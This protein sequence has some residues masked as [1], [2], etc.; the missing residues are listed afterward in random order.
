MPDQLQVPLG[1]L[2][3]LGVGGPA[4]RV[5]TAGSAAELVAAV[6]D[7]DAA[8]EPVL[9]LAGGSNVVVADA[10]FPG[11]VVLVR[12]RGI[13]TMRDGTGATRLTAQAGE[14]WDDLVARCVDR[15]LSGLECLSGIPGSTGATPIQNVGAYGQEVADTVVAVRAWDRVERCTVEL[16]RADCRFDY[17]DSMLKHTDRYVVLD[18]TFE[19]TPERQCRAL[20]YAEL[21]AAVGEEIGGRVPL[22]QARDAV[23]RLRRGKGMVIDPADP[24]SRS[25]G[26]F[27]T[28]PVLTTADYETLVHRAGASPPHWPQPDGRVKVPAGW[29]IERAGF[30]RGFGEGRVRVST[31]HSLALTNRGGA[32]AQEL[33]GLARDIRAGVRREFGVDLVNEPVLVGLNW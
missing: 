31:K 17:R 18:V 2:T 25:A 28:N 3:T 10:G 15:G 30:G 29:L 27:F 22:A 26:S 13:A 12:T 21:A 23:L 1:P 32:T 20:R 6:A 16:S 33:L 7:A 11:T 8:G 19:L 24:D 9:V 4:A 5:V 14:P